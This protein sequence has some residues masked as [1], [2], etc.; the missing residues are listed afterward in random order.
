MR[1]SAL[2]WAGLALMLIGAVLASAVQTAGG[3]KIRDVRFTGT[4]G[5][6]MSALLYVPPNAT[7]K[8]PAP[9][10]LAVHGYF[11]SRET[12]DGFAIEFA[13]RG[14]V[15]LALDQTGHGYSAPPTFSNGFG[16]PDGLRYLRSLD[17]VDKDNIG[18]EGHSMGGWT[19][20]N[21][22]ASQPEGYKAIVLEGS[23]TGKPFAP[24]GTPTFPRNLAVVFSQYDEFGATMWGAPKSRDVAA[25]LKLRAAFGEAGPVQVGKIYGDPA[26]GTG[27]VFHT[28]AITHAQDHFSITA[29][30]HAIDWLQ[31]N[32]KGGSPR[33]ASDQ[34]WYWKEVGTLIALAGF[35]VFLLGVFEALL[36]LPYFAPLAASPPLNEGGRGPGWWLALV[37]TAAIPALTYLPVFHLAEK[38]LPASPLLPQ[39]FTNQTVV[40]ALL[41]GI[42]A[43]AGVALFARARP[44]ISR[45]LLPAIL[46][47]M[48]T[49]SAGYAALAV[50]DAL[51][52][53]DFRF[54]VIGLK[55]L[56]RERFIDA[57]IY[58]V[59]FTA[60]F[61][62]ALSA[63]HRNL[64][65]KGTGRLAIYLG[66]VA[67]LAAGFVVFLLAQYLPL[68]FGGALLSPNQGLL[69]IMSIQFVVLL[70][71]VAVIATFTWLRTGR[72]LPGALICALFVTWY[73]VA[74]QAA[75]AA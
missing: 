52:K 47:A 55:L 36:R 9:G 45:P 10:V 27:R 33:P 28:P 65:R 58:L 12:Q 71:L 8:T 68:F 72:S 6:P 4:G 17:I 63:L 15:V 38:L 14:Y 49:V 61:I 73:V 13:R 39:A 25:S 35:V 74:G 40:W 56:N 21:A 34:I 59:P 16:G 30:G 11:N 70:A 1:R 43:F 67:A 51:F 62:L 24:E 23:S 42:L 19:V 7:A 5:A 41:N 64:T 20:V 18:L 54:W 32:L 46:I 53:I 69:T 75:Q 44:G 57:L 60:F 48:A 66:N 31:L 3:V 37:A 50:A 22:A 26:A 2:L 29:I